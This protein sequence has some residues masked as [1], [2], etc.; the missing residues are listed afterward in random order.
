[1]ACCVW[2]NITMKRG[3]PL[4]PQPQHRENVRPDAMM[5]P[6][7]RRAVHGRAQ[8]IARLWRN[9][10]F[11]SNS[12]IHLKKNKQKNK[13][14]SFSAH[15]SHVYFFKFSWISLSV[16]DMVASDEAVLSS[17]TAILSWLSNSASEI[18]RGEARAR[19]RVEVLL[20][21][22]SVRSAGWLCGTSSENK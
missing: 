10:Q 7:C 14:T 13:K 18:K 4:P 21:E 11:Q 12:L 8:L 22:G 6:D 15:L 19:L 3:V 5:G 2:H 1:M 16:L 17:V 20:Q 9:T